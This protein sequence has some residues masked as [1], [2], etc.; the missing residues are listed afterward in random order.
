MIKPKKSKVIANPSEKES[1]IQRAILEWLLLKKIFV[2]RN[3]TTGIFDPQRKVFRTLNGV[4]AR[5]GVADILG[6]FNGR[7]LAI[8]VKTSKGKLTD[9][10]ISFLSQF[11]DAGGIAFVARSI[12]DCE[13]NLNE[14]AARDLWPSISA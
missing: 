11:N 1:D 8:E 13:T 10:Q 3:Q 6:I 4:G 2:W 12:S 7:P 5:K 14:A 9:D